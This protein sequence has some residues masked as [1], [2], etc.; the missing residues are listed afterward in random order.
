[1]KYGLHDEKLMF[2]STELS[3]R[4]LHVN[5]MLVVLQLVFQI[6]DMLLC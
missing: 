1:M 6:S 3:R 4:V 2:C 5:L